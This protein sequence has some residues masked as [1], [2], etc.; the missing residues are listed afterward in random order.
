M[1]FRV[2]QLIE[3]LGG[4]KTP[5]DVKTS[6]EEYAK[7]QT[8]ASKAFG[9]LFLSLDADN[10]LLVGN[11]STAREVWEELALIYAPKDRATIASAKK[12]FFLLRRVD[13]ERVELFLARVDEVVGRLA[14]LGSTVEPAD[15]AYKYISEL[16]ETFDSIVQSLYLLS[17]AEFLPRTI[18]TRVLAELSRQCVGMVGAREHCVSLCLCPIPLVLLSDAVFP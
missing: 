18:R 1:F 10:K 16:P 8:N 13:G 15:I 11:C 17:D 2:G 12:E 5:P 9:Y 3:H 7:Y 4:I 6:P 14:Q